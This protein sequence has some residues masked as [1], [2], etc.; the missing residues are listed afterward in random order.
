MYLIVNASPLL[1]RGR[2]VDARVRVRHAVDASV[3][4]LAQDEGDGR[5][6]SQE[7]GEEMRR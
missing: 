5:A 1:A 2:D 3:V 6:L 4:A 7:E